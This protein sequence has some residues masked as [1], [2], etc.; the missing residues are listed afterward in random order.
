[1]GYFPVP[2]ISRDRNER[3]P[4]TNG[5]SHIALSSSIRRSLADSAAGHRTDDLH[6]ITL[7]QDRRRVRPPGGH[8]AVE[9]HRGEA[10]GHLELPQELLQGRP[11]ADLERLA[12]DDDPH[13]RKSRTGA[14]CGLPSLVV[15]RPR[16]VPFAGITQ[17]RFEGSR[18][19][20]P[21]SQ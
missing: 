8:L 3:P 11:V 15:G 21:G 17:G 1:E 19:P 6:P 5:S 9:R 7:A 20:R 18:T 4:S 10:T 2:T 13:R 14:R 12:V 16:R